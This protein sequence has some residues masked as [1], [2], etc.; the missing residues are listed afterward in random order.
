M[1]GFSAFSDQL[2]AIRN[3]CYSDLIKT[4]SSRWEFMAGL[5]MGFLQILKLNAD[6]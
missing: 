5:W 3:D 2:S 1:K 6:G 4:A